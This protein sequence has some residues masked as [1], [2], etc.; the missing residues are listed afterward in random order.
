MG[1]AEIS[2]RVRQEVSK[3][4]DRRADPRRGA[5]EG[6]I[7]AEVD[8][9][10][11]EM[12][13]R[14]FAGP[15]DPRVPALMHERLPDSV[16]RIVG[17]ADRALEKRFDLLGY[18]DLS[19]GDP[20]DWH[21]DP[22]AKR[23]APF[24][25]WT[26]LDPLDAPLVGDS[27]VVWE[28]NR[29]QW[30][31]TLGQAYRLTGDERY[32][33]MFADTIREWLQAN[34]PGMGINWTSSLEVAFRL[35][36]WCWALALFRGAAALTAEVR[37][38]LVG[39]IAIHASRIERYLSYYFSPNTHLTGEALGL[40]YAGTLFPA[41]PAAPRWQRLATDILVRQAER[42]ILPD[43][44]FMEQA[45]CY[46]RYTAEIYLHFV[47]LASKNGIFGPASVISRLERLL[48][49]LVALRRPDGSLPQI[50][51]AD[52]GWLLPFEVRSAG[53]GTGVFSTAAVVL[54]RGDYAWASAE[55]VPEVLWLLGRE[56]VEVFDRLE[57]HFPAQTPSRLLPDGGYAVM[58]SGW[59]D[60]ADQIIVDTGP[61]GCEFS[62][63]HG[64]ADLLSIQASFRGQP[65]IVDSGT[66]RYTDDGGWR[67]YY[68]GTAA[69]STVEIDHVG[70]ALPVGLFGWRDRPRARITR[71]ASTPDFDSVTAEHSAYTRLSDPV[72]H[73]RT[74]HFKKL[75]Y[76][77]VVDDLEGFAE[78]RVSLRFQFAPMSVIIDSSGWIRAGRDTAH[79]LFLRA[80]AT[81]ALEAA[82]CEGELEPK[83][84]W[85][86]SDYG[87]HEPAP[88]VVYSLTARLPVRLIT[89]LIP[90]DDRLA[91]PPSVCLC[92]EDGCL[93]G[94]TFDDGREVIR[95]DDLTCPSADVGQSMR[96][97]NDVRSADMARFD[98]ADIVEEARLD[99]FGH[100]G[101]KC[102]R[103][104]TEAVGKC[105]HHREAPEIPHLALG[106]VS[107]LPVGKATGSVSVQ[108]LGSPT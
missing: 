20:I 50:G 9:W 8:S 34:P 48:D 44:V 89:L 26:I 71:W 37:A 65:Y 90:I 97:V 99:V 73:R 35:I 51:D 22:V 29:H 56:G 85:V 102:E 13:P 55:L 25:H 93:H 83:Q 52:G 84:G 10:V 18:R 11:N 79:G 14:F 39:G 91:S 68:R 4:V 7:S 75:R 98:Q 40:F 86:S 45:T 24:V 76:C 43:G 5:F 96:R 61:L 88:M 33:G 60:Q 38:L 17:A 107:P 15:G 19:F 92:V 95:A 23:R 21:L 16:H 36:S 94:L 72:I 64:H 106:S 12:L 59:G 105:L 74:V 53:D 62:G 81:S 100:R 54:R 27:K 46:Q 69:H 101:P 2:C 41:M 108:S 57:C 66:F 82:I 28:L 42:Q 30:F 67:R 31:L 70:Q 103:A 1:F 78:H 32:A 6:S 58:R 47:I 49:A 3:W 104:W 87:C 80:F 63:G 77:V